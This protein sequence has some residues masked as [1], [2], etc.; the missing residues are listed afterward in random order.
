MLRHLAGSTTYS[1]PKHFDRPATDHMYLHHGATVRWEDVN[2]K[3]NVS[4]NH[5]YPWAIATQMVEQGP[6]DRFPANR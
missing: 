2:C 5:L 4:I 3:G 6:T 1:A